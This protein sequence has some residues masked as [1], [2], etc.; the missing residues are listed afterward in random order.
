MALTYEPALE[1]EIAQR[2]TEVE[3]GARNIDN[4]L[5]N[6]VLPDLSRVLLEAMLGGE[7]P[8]SVN[9]SVGDKGQFEYTLA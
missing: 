8:S 2:C 9:V 5:S 3:S 6:T 1:D 4:I 7:E